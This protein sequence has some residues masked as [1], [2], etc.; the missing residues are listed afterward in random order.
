MQHTVFMFRKGICRFLFFLQV[1]NPK[2]YRKSHSLKN[3]DDLELLLSMTSISVITE[4]SCSNLKLNAA[5]PPAQTPC[6][7][8]AWLEVK[9]TIW[10]YTTSLVEIFQ[11]DETKKRRYAL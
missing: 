10:T 7:L 11:N 4:F 6:L 1:T 5:A 8:L 2:R 9:L 3:L